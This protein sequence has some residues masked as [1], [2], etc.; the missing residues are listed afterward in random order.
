MACGGLKACEY[1]FRKQVHPVRRLLKVA[2][3]MKDFMDTVTYGPK[4]KR[5]KINIGIHYGPVVSGIIG[6]HKPQFS[7]IGDTVNKTS[8]VCSTGLKDQITISD[9]AYEFVK[10]S[11]FK[12]TARET[13]VPKINENVFL[14]RLTFRLKAL[15]GC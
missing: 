1:G 5:I 6:Y 14:I 2:F 4:R 12:F 3:Q 7:L 10:G 15:K 11:E 9:E 13:K 8:R